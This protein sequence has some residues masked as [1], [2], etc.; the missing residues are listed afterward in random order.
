M[1]I[2]ADS[3]GFFD[4]STGEPVELYYDPTD[5][6]FYN[7]LTGES[8]ELIGDAI[9]AALDTLI[10]VF[11]R[12]G[13]PQQPGRGRNQ[14]Y[15]PQYPPSYPQQQD[16]QGVSPGSFNAQGISLKWYALVGIGAAVGLLIAGKRLR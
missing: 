10:G 16:R 1:T 2:G 7:A 11:G 6:R 9:N 15:P 3:N 4:Y 12:Q 14:N 5:G 8:A 13:Y